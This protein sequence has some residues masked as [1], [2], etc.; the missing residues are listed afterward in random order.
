MTAKEV[1]LPLH[2]LYRF[3][4]FRV[5]MWCILA[6]S[7]VSNEVANLDGMATV[8]DMRV[9]GGG[10]M[11]VGRSNPKD[12]VGCWGSGLCLVPLTGGQ[13]PRVLGSG[14]AIFRYV[15]QARPPPCL[16]NLDRG[17]EPLQ[18]GEGK[19][20][21]LLSVLFGVWSETASE[22]SREKMEGGGLTWCVVV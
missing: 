19:L 22:K 12:V 2:M 17:N 5:S 20:R 9:E 4:T 21:Q 10:G 3:S 18:Q 11:G 16:Q 7:R 8:V 14:R 13:A 1:F 6:V 15:R